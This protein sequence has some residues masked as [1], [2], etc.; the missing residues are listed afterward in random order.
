MQ[1]SHSKL[2]KRLNIFI[3]LSIS[4]ISLNPLHSEIHFSKKHKKNL[5]PQ[6]PEVSHNLPIV[7]EGILKIKESYPDLNITAFYSQ[8][9]NDWIL[10]FSNY[11]KEY[12]FYWCNGSI[13]PE[14]ELSEK[15]EYWSVLYNYPEKLKDPAEMSEDEQLELKKFGTVANRR[16]GKGTAMYF[17]DAIY[18]SSSRRLLESH[19]QR[20]TFLGRS[21]TIHERIIQAVKNVEEKINNLALQDAEVKKFVDKIKSCDAFSWRVIDG[22]NRKSFHSLGIAIDILPVRITGEIFWSWARDKNPDTWMLTPL[23]HRWLPPKKV[24]QIFESEGFIW[25]G[26]WGIWDNMHF[27]YHPELLPPREFS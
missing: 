17:F 25:G 20:T 22:T 12:K 15:N 19:L 4:L 18:D 1:H 14:E 26:K 21:T 16:K 3:L 8:E 5:P 11:G 9:S 23:A 27:E 6:I 7:P 2:K 10:N 24:V 13:L